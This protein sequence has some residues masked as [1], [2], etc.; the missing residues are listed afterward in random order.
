[1]K[2][3]VN[4]ELLPSLEALETFH[5]FDFKPENMPA[6]R[7]QMA[8]MEAPSIIDENVRITEENIMGLDENDLKLRIYRLNSNEEALSPVLLWMHGGGYVLGTVEHDD[9]LCTRIVNEVHC[10]VVSVDYRLAPDHP[11]PAAIED[12]Y[13]ALKWIA[14]N[15]ESLQIDRSKIGIAG[16]SAGGGLTAALSLLARDRNYPSLCFQMPLYPMIDDRNNTP[17]SSEIKEGFV[18]NQ[19]ANEAGWKMYLG[20]LHGSGD[21]PPY[22][23]AARAED[24]SGLPFTYTCVG[25]LDPF[26]DESLT[27]VSKLAQAGV[28]VEFHLYPGA[29]HGFERSNQNA[30]ISKRAV[31]EYIQAVKFAFEKVNSK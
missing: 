5:D 2:K 7:E 12:C 27:Y 10:V 20:E 14:D 23:A 22:A 1:M 6:I 21:I 19:K 25:Q 18:W 24:Y 29:Y 11:Y 17:S 9:Q 13:T 31:N 3:R 15:S 8:E 28:D 4:P 16:A 30:E 26:R